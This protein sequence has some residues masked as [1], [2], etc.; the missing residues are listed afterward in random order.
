MAE[1]G[2][3]A[4][5]DEEFGREQRRGA[6]KLAHHCFFNPSLII[7]AVTHSYRRALGDTAADP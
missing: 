7:C 5:C 4:A 1:P 3:I 6:V 2:A